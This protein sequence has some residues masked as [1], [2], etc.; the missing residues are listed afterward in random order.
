MWEVERGVAK[1]RGSTTHSGTTSTGERG[2]LAPLGYGPQGL[3]Y[4]EV[5]SRSMSLFTS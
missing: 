3:Y 4:E 2:R 5:T 1:Q